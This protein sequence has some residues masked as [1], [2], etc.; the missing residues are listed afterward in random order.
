MRLSESDHGRAWLDQFAT[1]D[2][3]AAS[4][5][6]DGLVFVPA[7]DLE[8]EMRKKVESLARE[9]RVAWALYPVREVEDGE[10]I[11]E[12]VGSRVADVGSDANVRG[13]VGWAIHLIGDMARR[14]PLLFDRPSL[15]ALRDMKVR[16]VV[17]VDDLIGSGRRVQRYWNAFHRHPTIKSWCS[18]PGLDVVVL[19]YAASEIGAAALKR[20]SAEKAKA[21][22]LRVD[23]IRYLPRG[24]SYWSR[25]DWEAISQVCK[26]YARATSRPHLAL[27]L[28]GVFTTV[29][30]SYSVP[31]TAPA[32]LWVES[33]KWKALFPNR[34]VPPQLLQEIHQ[35]PIQWSLEDVLT[36]LGHS[37]LSGGDWSRQA[38]GDYRQYVLLLA[39]LAKGFR[40]ATLLGDAMG[41]SEESCVRLLKV[42]RRFQHA[43]ADNLL[44]PSGL[45]ELNYARSLHLLPWQPPALRDADFY[46]PM[47][48][49]GSGIDL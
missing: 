17:L 10:S 44:T 43:D 40:R 42:A 49:R 19:C 14:H 48:L 37:R 9:G 30:F 20:A 12:P 25:E 23:A 11:F 24:R 45:R 3:P 38:H 13:S 6:L 33:K 39:L 18:H 1:Q 28:G 29:V 36:Q 2:R 7:E 31:N 35:D 47:S 15:T 22:P 21:Q 26:R 8:L 16:R 46:Y 41:A 5:L 32:I 34:T 27:G 4:R